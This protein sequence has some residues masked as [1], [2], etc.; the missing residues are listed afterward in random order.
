MVFTNFGRQ[1]TIW[2]IGSD[3]DEYIQSIGIGDGSGTA[4]TTNT[5]L[6]NETNRVI[7]T[8]NPDFSSNFKVTFQGDLNSIQMS[9]TN[10]TEFAFFTSGAADVG[11]TWLREGFG[12]IAFDGSNEL[13]IIGT[14]EST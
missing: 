2:R 13:Q 3:V 7:I 11:S 1:A 4:N 8:G 5:I 6:V 9:G 14:I 10:L 12:S